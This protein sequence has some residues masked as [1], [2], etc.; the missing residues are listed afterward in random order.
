MMTKDEIKQ[1]LKHVPHFPGVYRYFNKDG[2]MIYVG[3]AKNLRKRV[4]SY[5]SKEPESRKVRHMVESIQRLEFTIVDTERDALLLENSLI[6]HNQPKYNI[7]LKDDKTY[8][9]IVIKNEPFPRIFL[10]RNVIKD[11]SEYFGPYTSVRKIR[12]LLELV[13][14]L[15]PIRTNN[16]NLFLR[17][18]ED[19][20]LRV[21]PEYYLK[22]ISGPKEEY[23]TEA[24]YNRGLEQVREIFK[25]RLGLVINMLQNRIKECVSKLEFEKADILRQQL[26]FIMEYQNNSIVFNT[27]VKDLDVFTIHLKEDQAY[28]NYLQVR[29]G[30]IVFTKTISIKSEV[31]KTLEEMLLS[32]IVQIQEKFKRT[33]SR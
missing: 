17:I 2:E 31:D 32:S 18:M 13:R 6:K 9:F 21:N 23:L 8:P 10:T 11:G 29:K 15:I 33:L 12:G 16:H 19:G 22:G 28:V 3:K 7:N 20:R 1:M 5:F 27:K 14:T 25:G 24:D 26:D 30:D 4:T